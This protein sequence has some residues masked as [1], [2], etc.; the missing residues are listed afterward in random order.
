M[1]RSY[2]AWVIGFIENINITEKATHL[3]ILA[4]SYKK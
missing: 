2:F 1:K 4:L 3:E